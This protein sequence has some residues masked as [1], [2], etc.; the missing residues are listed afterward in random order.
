MYDAKPRPIRTG[1]DPRALPD[2]AALRDEMGKL[3]HPARP[4]MSWSQVESL[5][6]SLFEHNGV[7]LQT[8][9]W[10][11]LAR[12]HLASV[13][14]MNEGLAIL[15]ALASHQWALMWPQQNHAR[16]EILSGLSLRL[17]KVFRTFSLH[18]ADLADLYQSEKLL[19]TL[20]DT[21]SR[22]ELKQAC[23]LDALSRQIHL[24]LTRLENSSPQEQ[25]IS[26][27]ALPPQALAAP[28]S[29]DPVS[30]LVYVIR[31]EPEINVDVVHETLPP[32]LPQKKWP[33]FMAGAFSALVI[34]GITLW[35][36][37]YTHREDHAAQALAASV[38]S[39]PT[40]LTAEQAGAL[41]QSAGINQ[42]AAGW[43][44][45]ASAQLDILAALPP[46]WA[47][48][49]GNQLFAQAQSLWPENPAVIPLKTRWQQQ[50]SINALPENVLTGWHEGMQQLQILT[51][52]LNALDGQ[53]DK[54]ITVSELKSAV[55]SM[56]NSFRQTV[57]V[58]EQL[59]LLTD[60]SPT[61]PLQPAQVQQVEQHLNTLITQLVQKKQQGVRAANSPLS[62]P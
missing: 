8:T 33:T 29:A 32:R 12:S 20:N 28:A 41:R 58:E 30:Q 38:T 17:Q 35:G 59:R 15:N 36:W 40:L 2:F 26:A 5:A 3:T 4:D 48:A 14:G 16:A 45:Q 1:S 44:K 18:Y 39:L 6:L 37:Q 57:P 62:E 46:D 24:A 22:Q 9:A 49:H 43:I 53:K 47:Q 7:E 21:L 55:F 51:D 27:V 13:A 50:V 42:Q 52:K 34:G 11:T 60:A 10:Y 61:K 23:Q 54:Y 19:N 25:A 31:P 56:T